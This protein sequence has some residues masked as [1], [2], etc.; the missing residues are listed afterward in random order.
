MQNTRTRQSGFTLMEVMFAVAILAI[1]LIFLACQFPVGLFASRDVVDQSRNLIESHNSQVMLEVQLSLVPNLNQAIDTRGKDEYYTNSPPGPDPAFPRF[2]FRDL[3]R[4]HLLVKPNVLAYSLDTD[5]PRLVL[6]DLE[7]FSDYIIKTSP[8]LLNPTIFPEFPFWPYQYG[9]DP[10]NPNT[11]PLITPVSN[12]VWPL[13]LRDIG[14]MNSPPVDESDPEVQKRL[15]DAGV[16]PFIDLDEYYRALNLAIFDTSLKRRYSWA[17]FTIEGEAQYYIFTFRQP[18]KEVQYAMQIPE[19]FLNPRIWDRSSNQPG[20][21]YE[22]GGMFD[23]PPALPWPMMP[24]HSDWDPLGFFGDRVFPVPW[25]VC[26]P[27]EY[28]YRYNWDSSNHVLVDHIGP[29]A[30]AAPAEIAAILRPGSILID[31]DPDDP[32]YINPNAVPGSA[33]NPRTTTGSGNVYEV[34]EILP[35]GTWETD[36]DTHA[37][38]ELTQLFAS[39]P[40]TY[41]VRLR[42][43]LRDH[44]HYFW[45]FPP[46]VI[47]DAFGNFMDYEDWQ[48][49]VG[50]TKKVIDIN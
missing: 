42:T 24:A 30:F 8:D 20:S 36:D 25:R 12:T 2:P 7:G 32:H 5:T 17:A 35:P 21:D 46:P 41:L 16:S 34:E 15:Q 14:Y 37:Y 19:S 13:G 11:F 47:R 10:D 18:R 6:D 1:G 29:T 33:R 28:W 49:V 31:G 43:N 40:D 45:V 4:V 27:P 23:S 22:A 9:D 3:W 26:L 50:V 48:P 38:Y 44:L 39:L